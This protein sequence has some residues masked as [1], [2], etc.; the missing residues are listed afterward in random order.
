[1][2]AWT[3]TEPTGV[4]YVA[5]VSTGEHGKSGSSWSY[6]VMTTFHIGRRKSDGAV[7]IKAVLYGKKPGNWQTQDA[8]AIWS[9]RRSTESTAVDYYKYLSGYISTTS[10]K[11]I[12]VAYYVDETKQAQKYI[13][14]FDK[15]AYTETESLSIEAYGD[16]FYIKVD[17]SWKQ[18]TPW[19]NVNGVWKQA[20]GRI[21]I[22]GSWV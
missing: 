20:V 10:F 18:A 8:E 14:K 11:Q 17:G 22:N 16:I 2:G 4:E 7:V 6:T 1:M 15:D 5:E 12:W 21:K 3:T 9:A 19:V 13:L